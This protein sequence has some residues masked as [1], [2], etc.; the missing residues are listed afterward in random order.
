LDNAAT[1]AAAATAAT[2]SAPFALATAATTSA[3]SAPAV[4]VAPSALPA[5]DVLLPAAGA[6]HAT[7]TSSTPEAD[8]LQPGETDTAETTKETETK[9]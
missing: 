9:S 1:A 8:W 3:L 4:V 7:A 5:P 6:V 2:A